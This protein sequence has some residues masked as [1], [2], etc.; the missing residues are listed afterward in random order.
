H[1]LSAGAAS[2]DPSGCDLPP[3]SFTESAVHPGGSNKVTLSW[4]DWIEGNSFRPQTLR[5]IAWLTGSINPGSGAWDRVPNPSTFV[6]ERSTSTAFDRE[7][8]A[9]SV[10]NSY[11]QILGG[12]FNGDG[13]ADMLFYGA[14]GAA[15]YL[16]FGAASGK[17]TSK[18]IAIW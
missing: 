7:G 10:G 11:T 17:F 12:D 3:D 4:T 16:W 14:G 9:A 8:G 5:T 6:A 13:R 2:F 15:D 18:S 1:G